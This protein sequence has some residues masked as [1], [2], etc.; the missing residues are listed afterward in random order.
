M[1]DGFYGVCTNLEDDITE[2]IRVNK[3]RWQI[4]ECFRIMKSEFKARSVYLSKD[5]RIMA[6]FMTCFIALMIYR[7]LEKKMDREYTCD[8]LISTLQNFNFFDANSHGF[9]P[10][11]TRTDLVDELHQKF[12]FNTAFEIIDNKKMKK[13]IRHT[14]SKKSTHFY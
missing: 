3:R 13:I 7:V 5:D 11:Y 9:L 6:H 8:Q 14:K 4:E 2:I 12:G 10:A 1:Y